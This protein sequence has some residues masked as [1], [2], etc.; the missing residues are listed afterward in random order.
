[1]EFFHQSRE[2]LGLLGSLSKSL[3]LICL[4]GKA[5][6]V[7]SSQQ[8]CFMRFLHDREEDKKECRGMNDEEKPTGV[9]GSTSEQLIRRVL[10]F[11]LSTAVLEEQTVL[12]VDHPEQQVYELSA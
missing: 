4:L 2:Q 1:M 10:P 6:M 9:Y 8:S 12:V 11:R 7:S 5:S 3:S